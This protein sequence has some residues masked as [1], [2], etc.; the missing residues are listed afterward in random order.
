MLRF[1]VAWNLWLAAGLSLVLAQG[2]ARRAPD[3]YTVFGFGWIEPALFWCV[4]V[5]T[6]VVAAGCFVAW[7][8]SVPTNTHGGTPRPQARGFDVIAKPQ[9]EAAAA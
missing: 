6:F 7:R 8:R 5:A 1:F 2:Y 9:G 3:Y 4:V